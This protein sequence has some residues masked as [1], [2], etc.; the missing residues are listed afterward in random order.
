MPA[1]DLLAHW[2][3][4]FS[5][6]V[7]LF[8]A[9]EFFAAHEAWETLWRAETELAPRRALQGLIQI[10][11]GYHKYFVQRLPVPAV[12]LLRRGLEKV[13]EG[14]TLADL[15]L[16]PFCQG[17]RDNIAQLERAHERDPLPRVNVPVL[18]PS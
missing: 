6:G 8:N 12:R 5:E 1:D 7:L 2:G 9:G 3:S 11:A 13:S 15:Q 14:D 4:A 18:A 17:V 10:A 16:A